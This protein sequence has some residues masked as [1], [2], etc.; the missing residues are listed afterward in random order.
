MRLADSSFLLALFLS[1]DRNFAAADR[2]AARPEAILVVS[3]VLAETLG[4]LQKRKGIDFARLV[5]QWMEGKPHFQ[6]V[7]TQR[8]HFDLASRIFVKAP[9]RLN[10]VD[11]VIVAWAVASSASV[12]TY[13][14][15]L[16]RAIRRQAA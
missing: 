9:E 6:F 4:V 16:R 1:G 15:D 7:F 10:Y 2:E 5:K 8:S 12:L 11:S 13:D 3:E 14:E